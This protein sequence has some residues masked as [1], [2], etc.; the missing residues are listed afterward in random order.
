MSKERNRVAAL[1]MAMVCHG[2]LT[3]W[4]AAAVNTLLVLQFPLLHSFL[5]SQRGRPRGSCC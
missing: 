1:V 4:P 5:L 2:T 3:G